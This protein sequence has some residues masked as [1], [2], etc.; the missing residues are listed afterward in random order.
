MSEQ[1]NPC[2]NISPFDKS[3][4]IDKVPA[5]C[6]PECDLPSQSDGPSTPEK[7]F[8]EDWIFQK[9]GLGYPRNDCDPVT[10]G[11]IIDDLQGEP[12]RE[13]IYRYSRSFR[14]CDEAM[15]TLFSNLIVIDEQGVSHP[16]PII[17]GTQERAV[18]FIIGDNIRQDNSLVVD[19]VRLPILSIRRSSIDY[20]QERYTYHKAVNLF[21][22]NKGVPQ[23]LFSEKKKNDTVLGFS[24]GIP[25]D[26]GYELVLWTYFV[27]DANQAI[28]QILLRFSPI[29]DLKIKNN[30]WETIVK[31]T[32]ITDNIDTEPGAEQNRVIKFQ[33][34][35]TV[36]TYVAQPIQRFKTI[37]REKIDIVRD[38]VDLDE[39]KEV[40][41]KLD[42]EV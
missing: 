28:E 21:R 3:L 25:V 33:F 29:V 27:E 36:E 34:N 37:L 2:P 15:K 38:N 12:S 31:I 18:A 22:D 5:F 6:N 24:R 13:V 9:N 4:N 42:I 10:S 7:P 41:A 19:R 40:L 32:G 20:V 39:I 8:L 11:K 26:L 14:A 1:L 17:W 23:H 30:T 16:I 35:F